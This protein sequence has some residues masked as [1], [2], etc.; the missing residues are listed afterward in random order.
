[1]GKDE[2]EAVNL[3]V[4][5]QL[6]NEDT[7]FLQNLDEN[8]KETGLPEYIMEIIQSEMKHMHSK[9]TPYRLKIVLKVTKM[10]ALVYLVVLRP[11]LAIFSPTTLEF[12]IQ[13]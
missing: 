6:Q 8:P 9:K 11:F 2:Q 7:F 4:N 3:N 10:R 5:N 13:Q 1:M 12:R